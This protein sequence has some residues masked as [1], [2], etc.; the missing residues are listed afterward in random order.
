[1]GWTERHRR[2]ATG[3]Q[4]TAQKASTT[5]STLKGEGVMPEIEMDPVE[6]AARS[7][8]VYVFYTDTGDVVTPFDP[9]KNREYRFL[10]NIEACSDGWHW[11]A[12][13]VV[14]SPNLYE[15]RGLAD[16]ALTGPSDPVDE[17]AKPV[18]HGAKVL[19]SPPH[20]SNFGFARLRVEE[21][22]ALEVLDEINNRTGYS[23]SALV[24][25]KFEIFVE[26]GSE[27]SDQV[28]GLLMALAEISGV[29]DVQAGQVNTG[30][31]YYYR[32]RK[33]RVG[34][35]EDEEA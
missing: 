5:D 1:M 29:T 35:P 32:P 25:G 22:R 4:T 9:D 34:R 13:A 28:C 15:L 6:S 16:A 30:Q 14:E 31:W 19:R 10:G 11:S 23:G 7:S 12:V 8:D 20:F 18:K 2:E 3:L 24:S 26:M 27:D 33:R 17:T 21:G